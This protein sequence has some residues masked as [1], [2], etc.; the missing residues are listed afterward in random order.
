MCLEGVGHIPN[1]Q[2]CQYFF[3]TIKMERRYMLKISNHSKTW[4]KKL[5]IYSKEWLIEKVHYNINEVT[6][7]NSGYNEPI[8]TV[9]WEFTITGVDCIQLVYFSTYLSEQLSP[10]FEQIFCF[11]ALPFGEFT[12]PEAFLVAIV[13]RHGKY[14]FE[15]NIGY[16]RM[17]RHIFVKL[18]NHILAI[19]CRLA[20]FHI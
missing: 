7:V 16:G 17:W 12:L 15:L 20:A 9:P 18:I 11:R 4:Q 1:C 8:F 19:I 2:K 3:W 5:T 6:S 13:S 14:L 10:F